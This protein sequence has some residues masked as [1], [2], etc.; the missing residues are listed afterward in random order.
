MRTTAARSSSQV[1]RGVLALCLAA[2]VSVWL[3][4]AAPPAA[5]ASPQPWWHLDASAAPTYLPPGGEGVIDVI[6]TNLGDAGADGKAHVVTVAD[7]LPAGLKALNMEGR[8]GRQ[9]FVNFEE[10]FQTVMAC[11]SAAELQAKQEKDEALSCTYAKKIAPFESL[12]VTINV[13]VEEPE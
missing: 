11:P 3:A 4:L 5:L 12:V 1:Q 2:L 6:A 13:K 10:F 9:G 8:T 7:K